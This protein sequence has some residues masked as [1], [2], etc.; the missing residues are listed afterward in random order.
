MFRAKPAMNVIVVQLLVDSSPDKF[1][2]DKIV[3]QN[4]WR[5][6]RLIIA[7]SISSDQV[8]KQEYCLTQAVARQLYPL[9]ERRHPCRRFASILLA[10]STER[11][12]G[13][14]DA[15]P[16][17]VL[18]SHCLARMFREIRESSAVTPEFRKGAFLW[19][20]LSCAKRAKPRGVSEL[21]NAH[22]GRSTTFQQVLWKTK[23]PSISTNQKARGAF[24]VA[25]PARDP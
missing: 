4:R 13:R 15:A 7:F 22:A 2:R 6:F 5:L 9:K 18:G 10:F 24:I 17:S 11:R 19:M 14:H 8:S 1:K 12:K 3:D 23:S 21:P 20:P 25:S 16:L